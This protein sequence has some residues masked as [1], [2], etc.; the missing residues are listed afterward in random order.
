MLAA[1]PPK[2]Y[3][4]LESAL[5]KVE[6]QFG[7]ILHHPGRAPSHVYFPTDCL[8]SLLIGTGAGE[9]E[10]GLVGN[11]GMVGIP[12]ALGQPASPVRAL[13]QGEGKA[14]RMRASRFTQELKRDSGLRDEIDR[15]AYI[16]MTTAMQIAACNNKHLLGARLARWLL[17]V[18][19]RL[20]R[21]EFRMTQEFLAVM[22]GVRRA[23]VTDAAGALQRR[24]LIRYVRGKVEILQPEG[25]C[26]VACTCYGVIRKL[27]TG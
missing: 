15:C 1:L 8:V 4:Q 10:V 7:Q 5:E 25:L 26:A 23:G 14:L 19:D 13:V 17:M 11:E 2:R 16:A 9:L 27:E 12:L 20:G 18:R 22:L 6:L 3:R 21:D 24:K